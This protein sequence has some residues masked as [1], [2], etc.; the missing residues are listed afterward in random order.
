MYMQITIFGS[1]Y[2]IE[3]IILCLVVGAILAMTSL[4]S[5]AGGVKE[6]FNAGKSILGS[7]L[8][9]NI[10][11]GVQSSFSK[12]SSPASYESYF[13]SLDGNTSGGAP[14]P[15]GQKLIFNDN[16]F[17]PECCPATYSNSMGCVCATK[18]QMQYIDQRGGNRT[19]SSEF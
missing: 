6:G 19:L 18:P 13:S 1:K 15:N 17:K 10:G 7:V 16:E 4:C 9:Y 14:L 3:V 12:V 2:S 5:C 8:D 11:D